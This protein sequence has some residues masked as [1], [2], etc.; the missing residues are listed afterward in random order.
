ME[1]SKKQDR[2]RKLKK[3]DM[4]EEELMMTLRMGPKACPDASPTSPPK[5]RRRGGHICAR[6]P[7]L[8]LLIPLIGHAPSSFPAQSKESFLCLNLLC[9]TSFYNWD[10]ISTYK[11]HPTLSPYNAGAPVRGRKS[12]PSLLTTLNIETRST[13][14][15]IH[16]IPCCLDCRPEKKSKPWF[17]HLLGASHGAGYSAYL[18]S[19]RFI[20]NR[21]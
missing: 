1:Q 13:V 3:L 17:V 10:A 12:I 21:T 7:C 16:S 8:S 15:C 14:Y 18:T 19:S 20:L 9:R 4:C 2:D 5:P 6:S 11:T